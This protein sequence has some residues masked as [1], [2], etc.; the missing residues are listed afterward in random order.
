M[1]PGTLPSKHMETV[2]LHVLMSPKQKRK[3]ETMAKR[4]GFTVS[5]LVRQIAD[6]QLRVERNIPGGK[7][8]V[9]R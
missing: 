9:S 1:K 5:I 8:R 7:R 6:G 4:M 3:L 2:Q